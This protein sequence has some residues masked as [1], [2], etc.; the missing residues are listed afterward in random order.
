MQRPEHLVSALRNAFPVRK[1]SGNAA[2]HDCAN[3]SAIRN[4]LHGL[5]WPEV[6]AAFILEHSGDLPLLSREAYLAFLP[7]WLQEAIEHPDGDVPPLLMVNLRNATNISQFTLA[8]AS[9]VIEV[10]KWVA[11]NDGFGSNDPVNVDSLTMIEAI[12]G[13]KGAQ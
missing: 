10:A 1:F 5:S 6:P 4:G 13:K 2:P 9:V 8:Q 12:W 11:A 7:A 3:C